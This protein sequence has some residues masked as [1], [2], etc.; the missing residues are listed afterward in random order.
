MR[1]SAFSKQSKGSLAPTR[2][3]ALQ[4][5]V[6]LST[7][8]HLQISLFH[9]SVVSVSVLFRSHLSCLRVK[10]AVDYQIYFGEDTKSCF[11]SKHSA[12]RKSLNQVISFCFVVAQFQS[13][14]CVVKCRNECFKCIFSAGITCVI[15]VSTCTGFPHFK[16]SVRTNRAASP[17]A[18]TQDVQVLFHFICCI[19]YFCWNSTNHSKFYFLQL[20]CKESAQMICNLNVMCV[21]TRTSKILITLYE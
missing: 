8:P 15:R 9:N 6:D 19:L 12:L 21:K 11:S 18:V 10:K 16:S 5:G 3:A 4:S 7:R 17:Q 14:A 2:A 20:F 13:C 1:Y